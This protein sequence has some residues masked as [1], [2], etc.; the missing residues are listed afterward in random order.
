[1]ISK[2]I[3]ATK[4]MGQLRKLKRQLESLE[5]EGAAGAG[6]VRVRM[7]GA[8]LVRR[9]TI[10]PEVVKGG[11]VELLEDLVKAAVNDASRKVDQQL[12]AQLASAEELGR[13]VAGRR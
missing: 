13:S 1:M 9:V 5:S 10:D 3:Q 8:R 12:Q 7:N 6:M 4:Q 11:D 2:F